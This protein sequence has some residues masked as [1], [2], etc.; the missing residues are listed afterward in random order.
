[1]DGVL[2]AFPVALAERLAAEELER[3]RWDDPGSW[4]LHIDGLR[5]ATC[6]PIGP[7]C[8]S[9]HVPGPSGGVVA[10]DLA[11]NVARRFR[12]DAPVRISVVG[13]SAAI[14][15]SRP[16]TDEDR[17]I[18]GEIYRQIGPLVA[19]NM[20]A[21]ARNLVVV[22]NGVRMTD[23]RMGHRHVDVAVT[24]NAHDLYD[25][26]VTTRDPFGIDPERIGMAHDV[27]VQ[28][29]QRHLLTVGD[30]NRAAVRTWR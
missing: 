24:L 23:C 2:D 1:M 18:A 27:P 6:L 8:V 11:R 9:I 29:L 26:E 28:A 20:D 5:G 3:G 10:E 15:W 12:T 25:I 21:K 30:G 7:Q 4:D 13:G 16:I 17:R 14:D 22:T 19:G